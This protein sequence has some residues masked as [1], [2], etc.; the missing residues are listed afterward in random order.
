MAGIDLSNNTMFFKYK[1]Y[2][3][4][5]D[6]ANLFNESNKVSNRTPD[7]RNC[8]Y[9]NPNFKFLSGLKGSFSFFTSDT[10]GEYKIIIQAIS[11]KDGSIRVSEKSFMVE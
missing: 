3:P 7:R 1:M 6:A 4:Q 2:A 11:K 8:L 10:K 9:W 5:N